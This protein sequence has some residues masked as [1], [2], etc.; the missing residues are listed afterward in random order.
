MLERI[1]QGGLT[2]EDCIR[3]AKD[4]ANPFR[5]F[6]FG[7]RVYHNYDPRAKILQAACDRV[8][9]QLKQRDPLW[10]SPANSKSSP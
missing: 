4:K 8:F 10:T 2:P 5:L 9:A 1:H 7:H 3:M 6:G